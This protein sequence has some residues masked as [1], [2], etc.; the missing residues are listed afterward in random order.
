[1]SE[2]VWRYAPSVVEAE[3]DRLLPSPPVKSNNGRD[4]LRHAMRSAVFGG[5][6]RL[7]SQLVL[8][9]AALVAGAEFDVK[10]ALPA[11]CALEMIH[12][13]SL[14]HDDLPAMDDADT[15][16]GRPS[17]HKQFGEAMAILAG[18]G[19]LT[20]AFETLVS[21]PGDAPNSLRVAQIIGQAAGEAGMVGGQALDIAWSDSGTDI[22]GESLL[23][24]HA[25]KTGALLRVSSEAGALVGGGDET[26]VAALCTYGTHLGRAFQIADDLLDATGDPNHTG[27]AASDE[28]NGKITATKIFGIERARQIAHDS[29]EQ[30]VAALQSF[31]SEAD[32]LRQLAGFV[33]DRTK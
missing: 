9:S 1:M 23:Q 7:R 21:Q 5:G 13:Y 11:A 26:Q 27:K 31:G 17:C 30:A 19:L 25:L 33:V 12:A 16:R 18:D 4:L 22:D 14:V 8:E 15:R 6:K 32:C 28:Q 10:R 29:R 24:M 3:L 2:I 20:L